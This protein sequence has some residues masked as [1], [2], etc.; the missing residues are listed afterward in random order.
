MIPTAADFEQLK[1]RLIGWMFQLPAEID[2]DAAEQVLRTRMHPMLYESAQRLQGIMQQG[3]PGFVRRVA[4]RVGTADIFRVFPQALPYI[5][6]YEQG[7]MD[8][9]LRTQIFRDLSVL[10]A[11][12]DRPFLERLTAAVLMQKVI[13]EMLRHFQQENGNRLSSDAF[14]DLFTSLKRSEQP[15]P[16]HLQ[17]QTEQVIVRGHGEDSY[18]I[19]THLRMVDSVR[20][21]YHV[22]LQH[23]T[24]L[25]QSVVDHMLTIPFDRAM[26][27]GFTLDIA[28]ERAYE[29]FTEPIRCVV[30]PTQLQ[31]IR[32]RGS[33]VYTYIGR[34][35]DIRLFEEDIDVFP[36]ESHPLPADHVAAIRLT[37]TLAEITRLDRSSRLTVFV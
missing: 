10:T 5:Q 22:E 17:P 6:Q 14:W 32:Q 34:E 3:G 25:R 12:V 7:K 4:Q 26:Q 21:S 19:D 18:L 24:V 27:N 2:I 28:F 30:T 13:S 36:G 35:G 16:Q 15:A 8:V 33:A 1:C 9:A 23:P 31:Q 29:V 37:P 20:H 11:I